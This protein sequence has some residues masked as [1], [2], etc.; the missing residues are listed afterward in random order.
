ME[1]KELI[2]T[3]DLNYE[4]DKSTSDQQTYKL[5]TLSSPYQLTQMIKEPTRTTQKTSSVI[6]LIL[7]NKPEH[8]SVN[9]QFSRI[10]KLAYWKNNRSTSITEMLMNDNSTTDLK[11]IAKLFNEYLLTLV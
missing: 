2:L 10:N 3:G 9:N 7:T 6:D 4:V 8:I 11:I 5:L 1:N